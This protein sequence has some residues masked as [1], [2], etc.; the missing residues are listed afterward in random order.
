M[1][2]TAGLEKLKQAG[3]TPIGFG[4]IYPWASCH[5]ITGFNQKCVPQAVREKDYAAASGEFTDPGYVK[6]LEYFKGLNDKGYFSMGANSTEH[7]MA[8]EMFY[9]GQVAMVYVELEEFRDIEEK[10]AGN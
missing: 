7:N 10:M 3:V 6:A 2:F 4:N 8:L 5:Y 1:E 9:G